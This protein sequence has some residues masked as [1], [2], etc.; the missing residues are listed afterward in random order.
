MTVPD[1][2]R[3]ADQATPNPYA[4]ATAPAAAALRP[5]PRSI[6]LAGESIRFA[7]R[8]EWSD[9]VVAMGDRGRQVR[10][11]VAIGLLG[12]G[13]G[14]LLRTQGVSAI[15]LLWFA[16]LLAVAWGC[17][18]Y[19]QSGRRLASRYLQQTPRALGER[20]GEISRETITIRSRSGWHRLRWA[21][22]TGIQLHPGLIVVSLNPQHASLVLLPARFFTPADWQALRDALATMAELLPLRPHWNG[23]EDAEHLKQGT[24]ESF[25]AFPESPPAEAL[26]LSGVLRMGDVRVTRFLWRLCRPAVGATILSALAT[27]GAWVAF[28]F[29]VPGLVIGSVF[30][31]AGLVTLLRL[32]RFLHGVLCQPGQ[33]LLRMQVRVAKAGLWI[34]TP[35]GLA[36]SRWSEFGDLLEGE[37]VLLLRQSP[38][39]TMIVALARRMLEDPRRWPELCSL[40]RR[41]I[42]DRTDE[43]ER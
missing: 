30:A 31:F 4:P 34:A 36:H 5:R 27:V 42:N 22:V 11:A 29:S 43:S 13:L 7:G 8:L 28:G 41:H 24:V 26:Q 15:G 21:S 25:D 9:L 19:L 3:V 33:P 14:L 32:A 6:P 40:V 35:R 38:S 16:L 20:S 12:A 1:P 10:F 17:G 39:S 2:D 37:G 23:A 18:A